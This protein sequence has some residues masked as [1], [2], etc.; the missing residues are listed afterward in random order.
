MSIGAKRTGID[1]QAKD[2]ALADAHWLLATSRQPAP[3]I[4]C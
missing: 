4:R 2:L 1:L 3:F